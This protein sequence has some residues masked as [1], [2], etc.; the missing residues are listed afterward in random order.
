MCRHSVIWLFFFFCY[1]NR[2]R[3]NL[4]RF[5]SGS[6]TCMVVWQDD[7]SVFTFLQ[8]SSDRDSSKFTDFL[9]VGNLLDYV[10]RVPFVAGHPWRSCDT[11][12]RRA[13][14]HCLSLGVRNE[15]TKLWTKINMERSAVAY[16]RR[17]VAW[18]G[19]APGVDTRQILSASWFV[20]RE[21]TILSA[22]GIKVWQTWEFQRW[23]HHQ[24]C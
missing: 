4:I 2:H 23:R 24:D 21:Q 8:V 19:V 3:Q 17:D 20:G 9:N 1:Q 12:C 5:F 6:M 18:R 14:H 22:S 7:I 13:A 15:A 11:H 10:V 16:S